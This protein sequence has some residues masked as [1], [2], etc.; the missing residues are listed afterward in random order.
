VEF[1]FRAASLDFLHRTFEDA[2][3]FGTYF[4]VAVV[5]GQL[6]ARFRM[7][8]RRSR[9]GTHSAAYLLSGSW[10]CS[11]GGP[12]REGG[13]PAHRKLFHAEVAVL[14]AG[15]DGQLSAAGVGRT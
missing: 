1:L 2:M 6:V 12:D 8:N 11:V 4:I 5:M 10:R 13:G 14:L 9:G 7:R 3:M 15:A